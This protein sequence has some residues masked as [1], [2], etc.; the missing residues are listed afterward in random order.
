M[1]INAHNKIELNQATL[2]KIKDIQNPISVLSVIGPYRSGKSY[3]MNVLTKGKAKFATGSSTNPCTQGVWIELLNPT[4]ASIGPSTM[5]MDTEGLFSYNRNEAFD[6]TLFLFTTLVSSVMIYN[7]LGIIDESA[8]ENFAFLTNMA[9][10]FVKNIGKK[11]ND[12]SVTFFDENLK[13]M[14]PHFVWLLRDFSLNLQIDDDK[15]M[16]TPNEYFEYSLMVR[17]RSSNQKSTI[18]NNA[19]AQ[20]DFDAKIGNVEHGNKGVD[21]LVRHSVISQYSDDQK[22]LIRKAIKHYFPDRDC[23]TLIRPVNDEK[24]L[25]KIEN[26]NPSSIRSDFLTQID[27]LSSHIDNILKP[28]KVKNML[29]NGETLVQFIQII[30]DAINEHSIPEI[31]TTLERIS[32]VELRQNVDQ[33]MKVFDVEIDKFKITFPLEDATLL[34]KVSEIKT[35]LLKILLT[36]TSL[37][38]EYFASL[39]K[40]FDK[41]ILKRQTKLLSINYDAGRTMNEILAREL[42]TDFNAAI[43][44]V[45]DRQDIDYVVM[46]KL[47]KTI[48]KFVNKAVGLSI[49]PILNDYLLP[50]L[51]NAVLVYFK[52]ILQE[53]TEKLHGKMIDESSL[54]GKYEASQEMLQKQ[55]EITQQIISENKFNKD[56]TIRLF[57]DRIT[58]LQRIVEEKTSSLRSEDQLNELIRKFSENGNNVN[59]VGIFEVVIKSIEELRTEQRKA[60]RLFQEQ[61]D[62]GIRLNESN[63]VLEERLAH[64][65]ELDKLKLDNEQ[66]LLSVKMEHREEINHLNGL[67]KKLENKI[68]DLTTNTSTK[69]NEIRVL[70]EKIKS[71]DKLKGT[72]IQFSELVCNV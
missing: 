42:I 37:S 1:T 13:S 59:Q 39:I 8:L 2:L 50:S 3:L 18:H 41:Q 67:V 34:L 64:K 51:M 30:T 38:Q 31:K 43:S 49:K 72:Q 24:L 26:A 33:A 25:Q 40:L 32:A 46:R 69:D 70:Q 20:N 62:Q 44:E 28:K 17:P 21:N 12:N 6:M 14:F 23:F 57:E 15:Q 65:N 29:L 36:E 60:L 68:V 61:N 47:E 27:H 45:A 52:S 66:H 10:V 48:T 5:L 9:N 35:N 4:N 54:K 19:N 56:Q 71:D 16:L 55:K 7:S 63:L 11:P 58:H 22:N 53:F